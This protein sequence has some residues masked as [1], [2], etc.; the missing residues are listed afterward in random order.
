MP[1]S[2]LPSGDD[3]TC[4]NCTYGEVAI[5]DDSV[6]RVDCHRYPPLLFVVDGDPQTAFP[7]VEGTDW[8]GEWLDS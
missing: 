1:P 6:P 2:P 5:G 4:S 7:Q 3:A 8:C